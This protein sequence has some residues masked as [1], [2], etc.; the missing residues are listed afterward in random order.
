MK[1]EHRKELETNALANYLG[2]ALQHAK[3]GPSQKVVLYG[4]LAVLVVVL[5][6]TFVYFSTRSKDS[7][8]LR[9]EQWDELNL[10]VKSDLKP[11]DLSKLAEEYPGMPPPTLERLDELNKFEAANAGTP[12]A[13]LV[14]YQK[15]RQLLQKSADLG[16]HVA[17][18]NAQKCLTKA[19]DLYEK[20]ID[21]SSDVPYLAQEA[22]FNGAKASE[23]I[24]DFDK[25]K[26]LYE[27]LKKEYPK[28]MYLPET[29][30][31]LA[32]LNDPKEVEEL[33]KLLVGK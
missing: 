21:E 30:K 14:R 18:S 10:K 4:G 31:A 7:D 25:A 26:K 22:L 8:A 33:K 27:R 23:D 6:A 24:G 11:S 17:R 32:R 5:I 15:A 3:E 19:R 28:S 16:S 12:Q 9:W 2:T 29:D 20:L 13:R 1:A